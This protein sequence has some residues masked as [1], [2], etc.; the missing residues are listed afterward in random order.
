MALTTT[1]V[2]VLPTG[3]GSYTVYF[4]ASH[5]SLGAV[6]MQKGRVI[7]YASRQLKQEERE[8]GKKF[9]VDVDAWM[10]LRAAGKSDCLSGTLSYSDIYEIVLKEVS[11]IHVQVGKPHVAVQGSVDYLGVEIIRYRGVDVQN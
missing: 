4:D 3:S 1:P 6:L 5:I 10:D 7:A 2:L 8:L 11:A 9:L